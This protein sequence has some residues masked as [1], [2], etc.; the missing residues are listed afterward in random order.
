M[1]GLQGGSNLPPGL[2]T[3]AKQDEMI[4]AIQGISILVPVATNP[5]IYNV[6]MPLANTEYSQSLSNNTK[7]LLIRCRT[8]SDIRFAFQ[9]GH[10]ATTYVTLKGGA[11][12]SE[13]NLDLDGATIYL[14]STEAA[15]I[16]EILQWT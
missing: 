16:V 11:V 14:R 2:A 10:T 9:P 7:R 5:T 15:Q 6:S 13:E 3:E 4:D 8:R 1:S 12:Y